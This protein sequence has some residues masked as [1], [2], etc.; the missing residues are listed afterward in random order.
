M[1]N[2]NTPSDDSTVLRRGVLHGSR[3]LDSRDP[4]LIRKETSDNVDD[5]LIE[6]P[7]PELFTDDFDVIRVLHVDDDPQYTE[8]T[9]TMLEDRGSNLDVTGETSVVEAMKHLE[10]SS[11][12][13]IISDYEMPNTDGLEFLDIVRETYPDLPFILFTGKGSEEIASEA[14]REGVTD[15]VRK[16]GGTEQFE[17][18][19][20]RVNN[21]VERY[22]AE[23]RFWEAMSWYKHLVEQN[24]AGVFIF[25]EG[26]LIYVNKRMA[27]LF[28]STQT[29]LMNSP[30][31]VIRDESSET[32]FTTF[33]SEIVEDDDRFRC[34]FGGQRTD[35]TEIS[36]EVN[37]GFIQYNGEDAYI[38]VVWDRN[39]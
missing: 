29:E 9:T 23:Q 36:L 13:C 10:D 20:N 35:G 24:L 26:E 2:T 5:D 15:Y 11:V 34:T 14:I 28:G 31:K 1:Q 3:R 39:N 8:L 6:L 22:K 21:A 33:L 32:S 25:Q 12:D 38:G 27:T 4:P 19:S 17:V 18:L 37:G 7:M 30:P 16:K